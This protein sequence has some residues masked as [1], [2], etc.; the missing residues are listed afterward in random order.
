MAI[1]EADGRARIV[2]AGR[3]TAQARGAEAEAL[4]CQ[5]LACNGVRILERNLRCRGGE[6][7]V[8]GIDRDTLVFVEVRLRTGVRFG[9]PAE[10]ITAHKRRRI[11][12]AARWWLAHEGRRHACRPCRFDAILL[13]SLD[14]RTIEWLR[15]AFVDP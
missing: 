14:I 15:A 9:G 8:I 5:Y 1:E 4:A 11:T 10:S 2:D 3:G 7:D 12:H 6:V 13:S